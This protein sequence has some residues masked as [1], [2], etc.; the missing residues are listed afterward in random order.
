MFRERRNYENQQRR[1]YN[2]VGRY[3]IPLIRKQ[4]IDDSVLDAHWIPFNMAKTCKDPENTVV[5]FFVDDYQFERVWKD[6][7]R[8][9]E[10]L[11]RFKAVCSPDFSIYVDFPKALQ[12]YSHFKS[13]W[14]AAFW[15]ERGIN[16][17]PT[18][19]WSD[20][21]SFEWCFDGCAKKYDV[22]VIAT[23]GVLNNKDAIDRF[24]EGVRRACAVL[25]PKKLVILSQYSDTFERIGMENE[26]EERIKRKWLFGKRKTAGY[27]LGKTEIVFIKN[28]NLE[29][30]EAL[31]RAL[32]DAKRQDVC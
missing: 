15:Q 23:A 17:I 12:I 19:S 24:A 4:E 16:V 25:E 29:R 5:H 32:R 14:C 8:Y 30:L 28:N 6:P 10:M 3:D 22:A 1:I 31:K 26:I 27:Y 7:E 2:G 21:E 13:H 9:A 11:S 18:L 20:N